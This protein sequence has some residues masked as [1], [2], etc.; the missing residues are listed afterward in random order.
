[1]IETYVEV[2]ER[3]RSDHHGR[4]RPAFTVRAVKDERRE[5]IF[6]ETR[7]HRLQEPV[8]T[9]NTHTEHYQC[10]QMK[11]IKQTEI[12]HFTN[13]FMRLYK[14]HKRKIMKLSD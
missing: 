14:T 10:D 6:S 7:F 9:L 12:N 4:G 5:R 2:P 13:A 3:E 8:E 1:M 11:V